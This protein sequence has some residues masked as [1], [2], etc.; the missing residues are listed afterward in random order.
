MDYE[1]SEKYK[2][3]SE[4][5]IDAIPE[6]QW[7]REAGIKIAYERSFAEKKKSSKEVLAECRKVPD[8]WK[9]YCPY[10]FRIIIYESNI[11]HLTENQVKVL[12][13]HEHLH[14]GLNEKN[15]ELTYTVDP[16]DIEDFYSIIDRFGTRW[17][18]MGQDI[19]DITRGGG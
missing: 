2:V 12:L 9:L 16:H 17:A 6:L 10:D 11:V 19:P 8:E 1:L 7:I 14:I 3:M 5:V 4:A 18:D 13:W 15:G